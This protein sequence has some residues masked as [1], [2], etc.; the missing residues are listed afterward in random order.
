[1]RQTAVPSLIFTL[2][3]QDTGSFRENEA[4]GYRIEKERMG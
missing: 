2:H 1:M 3:V 4:V